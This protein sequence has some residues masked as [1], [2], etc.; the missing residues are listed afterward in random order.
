MNRAD[1][2]DL[3]HPTTRGIMASANYL[4]A[5]DH[6]T[7]VS[8]LLLTTDGLLEADGEIALLLVRE[9]RERDR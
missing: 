2:P 3:L 4:A 9:T 1:L 5:L 7:S 6:D 8:K